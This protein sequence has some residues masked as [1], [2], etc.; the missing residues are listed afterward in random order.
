M[1]F[2]R[3]T[4]L[5][6]T[7]KKSSNEE[8][9][10]SETEYQKLSRFDDFGYIKS[11]YQLSSRQLLYINYSVYVHINFCCVKMHFK[12]FFLLLVLRR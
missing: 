11:S 8:N 2:F 9:L 4:I 7:R 1:F 6:A 3:K 12:H 5:C 10:K